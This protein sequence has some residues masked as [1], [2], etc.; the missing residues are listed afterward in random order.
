MNRRVSD[1]RLKFREISVKIIAIENE[2]PGV[3]SGDFAPLLEPE[4]HRVWELYL[5]GAI[6][7]FYFRL[8]VHCA[9]LILECAD[10][11]EA[12]LL[13]STLPLVRNHLIDFELVPLS[14]YPGLARLFKENTGICT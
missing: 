2:L 6:R 4:A 13:L 9:V 10:I 11:A 7:E 12:R 3:T 8:D 5:S 1:S 14:P